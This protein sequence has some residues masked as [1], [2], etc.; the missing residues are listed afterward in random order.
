MLYLKHKNFSL[1]HDHMLLPK[2]V[3]RHR[4]FYKTNKLDKHVVLLQ[5]IG[6]F[7]M[8]LFYHVCS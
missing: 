7:Y 1:Q 4:S 6:D 2:F 3:V 5:Y 8:K